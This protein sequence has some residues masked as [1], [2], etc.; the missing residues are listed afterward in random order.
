MI[1]IQDYLNNIQKTDDG[2]T[3]INAAK[4]GQNPS[5]VMYTNGGAPEAMLFCE[6][7]DGNINTQG[8]VFLCNGGNQILNLTDEN[9][10]HQHAI[11][12]YATH[13]DK[14]DF[15]LVYRGITKE[16]L[17]TNID[18]LAENNFVSKD[19]IHA[20]ILNDKHAITHALDGNKEPI[21]SNNKYAQIHEQNYNTVKNIEF[22]ESTVIDCVD[23]RLFRTAKYIVSSIAAAFTPSYLE[24]IKNKLQ[25]PNGIIVQNHIGSMT[26][27]L[28][29]EYCG[30]INA[31]ANGI[32][33]QFLPKVAKTINP[34]NI[35][36]ITQLTIDSITRTYDAVKS[37]VNENIPIE[38]QLVSTS[39][40]E[41]IWP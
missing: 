12:E 25:N 1:K 18:N 33:G 20:F 22:D 15:V 16:Q 24:H 29:G 9:A 37:I 6:K 5:I 34:D 13:F 8:R 26:E 41:K 3:T 40:G 7:V 35:T 39:T 21:Y 31:A 30:G 28:P 4:N 14:P 32:D 2:I 36:D 27:D 10:F 38:K 19:K 17:E 23:S 11:A